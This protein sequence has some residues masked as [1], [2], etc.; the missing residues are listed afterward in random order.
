MSARPVG[1]IIR[2]P[3]LSSVNHDFAGRIVTLVAQHANAEKSKTVK[4]D[5]V[6]GVTMIGTTGGPRGRLPTFWEV[7]GAR[8]RKQAFC[9]DPEAV[10]DITS[11]ARPVSRSEHRPRLRSVPA[12][13]MKNVVRFAANHTGVDGMP[14]HA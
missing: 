12:L 14:V 13:P 1:M 7:D 3:N 9:A 8:Y 5:D 10:R 4:S 6:A 2:L 11:V